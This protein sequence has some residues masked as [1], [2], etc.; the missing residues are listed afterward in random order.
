MCKE[1]EEG[2]SLYQGFDLVNVLVGG[3]LKGQIETHM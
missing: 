3:E 1:R 2:S